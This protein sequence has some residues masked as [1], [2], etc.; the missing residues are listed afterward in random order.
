MASIIISSVIQV[1]LFTL[2]PFIWWLITARKKMSFF[3]WIGLKKIEDAKDKKTAL[4]TAVTAVLFLA[5]SVL[6]LTSLKGVEMATSE[7]AGLGAKAIPSILI[8]AAFQTALAE[9]IVFRGFLLKRISNK[10]GFAA[11]NTIQAVIFGLMHGIM[12]F[13][14][15]DPLKATLITAFTGAIGWAMG[16]INEKKAGGSLIPSW[17]IHTCANIFSGLCAAFMLFA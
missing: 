10:F 17:T 8:Y 1:A 2:I 7:F 14:A 13:S 3:S 4:W 12:F 11:G 15:V 9:E 5:V 6:I 16:F